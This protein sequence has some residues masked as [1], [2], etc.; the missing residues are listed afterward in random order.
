MGRRRKHNKT[1]DDRNVESSSKSVQGDFQGAKPNHETSNQPQCVDDHAIQ[2]V[3]YNSSNQKFDLNIDEL[4]G[5]LSSP[6]VR[7]A[8]ISVVSIAGAFRK[9]KSFMMSFFLR[10]LNET[11][12]HNR[13]NWLDDEESALSGFEWRS[14]YHAHTTGIWIW[15]KVFTKVL[16]SGEKIGVMLMDTQG[17]F[18]SNSTPKDNILIF[19]L[20]TM[21]SSIQ[22]YNLKDNIQEDNLQY[23]QLFT[24][25][26]KLAFEQTEQKPFQ[27]LLFLVRD[28]SS[29]HEAPYGFKGGRE[30]LEQQLQVKVNQAVE[31]ASVRNHIKSCYERLDCFLMP[32]PGF[33]ATKA[34]EFRGQLK[35]IESDFKDMLKKLLPA[36]LAPENILPN[37]ISGNKLSGPA[38]VTYIKSCWNSFSKDDTPT[39]QT[40]LGAICEANNLTAAADATE[41]YHQKMSKATD[42]N[43]PILLFDEMVRLH[44]S[45]LDQSLEMFKSKTKIGDEIQKNKHLEKLRNDLQ[46]HQMAYFGMNEAKNNKNLKETIQNLSND[47]DKYKSTSEAQEASIQ[48]MKQQMEEYKNSS[49]EDRKRLDSAL[50]QFAIDKKRLEEALQNLKESDKQKKEQVEVEL[51]ENKKDFEEVKRRLKKEFDDLKK[52]VQ[53]ENENIRKGELINM[54]KRYKILLDE[55]TKRRNAEKA[56][57]K[58]VF[59]EHQKA[60]EASK[61]A[62]EI[63]LEKMKKESSRNEEIS[64][65]IL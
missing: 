16:L 33:I 29:P 28:W 22:I 41:F 20:S 1:H 63:E 23:L 11:Y 55:E 65:T 32:H 49:I 46:N 43:S 57:I 30:I 62:I 31:L 51:A 40:I 26:G 52:S 50:E 60:S 39:P 45:I 35:H 17:T 44:C 53:T 19:S 25:Y 6:D 38:F 2:I 47:V 59:N 37:K 24:E 4:E 18:D 56:R 58:K 36:L 42:Q 34:P 14:G 7:D 13:K 10:Y 48:R 61:K 3:S 8:Y 9:G 27:K 54:E 12:T 21:L 5:I 64:C 15:S